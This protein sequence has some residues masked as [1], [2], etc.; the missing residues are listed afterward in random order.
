MSPH[1][2]QVI[3]SG[4][5][6]EQAGPA[7]S[8]HAR[9]TVLFVTKTTGYG[10]A[11]IHLLQLMRRVQEPGVQLSLLCVEDDVFSER[12]DSDQTVEV[13]TCKRVPESLW[14]WVRLFRASQPDVVVFIYTWIWCFPSIAPVGAW[15]AG[16]RKLYAIQHALPPGVPPKV[17]GRS[18]RAV[19]RRLIGKRARHLLG[20]MVRPNLWDKTICVSNAVRE[21]LIRDYR[22]PPKRTLTIHNGVSLS[23]FA[24]SGSD[25]IAVR[26]RLGLRS[27]EFVLVCAARLTEEKGIGI[28][29]RAIARALRDS[30]PCKCIMVGDGPLREQLLEQAQ[31]LGLLGHVFFEGFQKD[32]RPYLQASSAFVL[33]SHSEGGGGPLSVLEAMACGLPC[34]VT[35]VG[36]SVE[37]I[38]HQ[39][40]GL[41]VPPASVDAVADAISYL[42]THPHEREQMARMARTRACEAFDIENAM[43]KI[44]RVILS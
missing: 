13:I 23:E 7:R 36:G 27:D 2:S 22:F 21:A 40:H 35:G 19:L 41:V 14:D 33:T 44:R 39:V 29:L 3:E 10:G 30:V 11:E 25:G 31:E 20:S 17:E 32:V 37:A 28:L 24:P 34:I 4:L 5:S 26:N 8:A 15:L 38:T 6:P 12:L 9:R 1:E 16:I 43:P 42:A 18:I